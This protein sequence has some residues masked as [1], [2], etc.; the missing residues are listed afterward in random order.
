MVEASGEASH[1]LVTAREAKAAGRLRSNQTLYGQ[2]WVTT[3][4]AI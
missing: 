1:E 3:I 4:E 2:I